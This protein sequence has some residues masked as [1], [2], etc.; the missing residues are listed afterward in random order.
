MFT[1]GIL[2]WA[3]TGVAGQDPTPAAFA[4]AAMEEVA[5][6][7]DVGVAIAEGY[8]KLGP[9]FPGMGEHWI[10]PT[11][12]IE[13]RL[14]PQ[15]PPVLAYARVDGERRFVGFAFTHV[16]GPEESIPE[17][18]FP[19][20]AWHDHSGGVDEESVLL[21]G[22]VSIHGR[23][24]GFRL[25]MVHVWAPLENADGLLAQNNW[26]LPFVRAGL[27]V[28]QH[29]T[30]EAARA[31]STGG[32]GSEFYRALLQEGLRLEGHNLDVAS[33]AF[34]QAGEDA[35]EWVAGQRAGEGHARAMAELEQIWRVL[36]ERLQAELPADVFDGIRILNL[37]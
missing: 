5:R 14:D 26:A 18:P 6:F 25:S 3:P 23:S 1:W 15:R 30:I 9:D 29:V 34:A 13:G 33:A 20:H 37:G 10:N 24:R 16:L 11:L 22:P 27:S 7:S 17:G 2:L 35:D 31:L 12:V 28:P 32:E 21:S 36:W 4:S 8:R 19:S